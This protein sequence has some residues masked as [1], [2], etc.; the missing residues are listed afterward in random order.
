MEETTGSAIRRL[1]RNVGAEHIHDLVQVRMCD[2]IA[3]GVP[4]AVPYRLRHFQFRVEKVLREGEA[5]N[6]KM[7]AVKGGDVMERLAIPPGPRVG[8]ILNTLLEEVL[9]APEKNTREYL[10]KRVE[11]LHKMSDEELA[12][13]RK[14]AQERVQLL[15]E[16]RVGEIKK[17][18]YVK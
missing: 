12:E 13:M 3:T 7:L 9:D 14:Q 8:H 4:K 10:L 15:E 18:Y 16:E 11:E 1:I 5:T 17:K 6:V 2:R